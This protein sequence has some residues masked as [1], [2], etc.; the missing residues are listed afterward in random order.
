MMLRPGGYATLTSPEG[1][2]EADTYSCGHCNAI[3]HV[4]AQQDASEIGGLC[5]CCMQLICEKCLG[6]ECV[7]FMKKIENWEQRNY[8]LRSYGI[9]VPF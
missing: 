1:V 3:R 9:T 7:P 4:K 8:A 2:K 6:G 5:K